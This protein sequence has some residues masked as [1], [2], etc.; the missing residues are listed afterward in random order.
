MIYSTYSI[1]SPKKLYKLSKLGGAGEVIWTKSKRKAVFS[2]ENVHY[3]Q[4]GPLVWL[5][6][7]LERIIVF[8]KLILWHKMRKLDRG[9]K[10][11]LPPQLTELTFL[12]ALPSNNNPHTQQWFSS[13]QK[14]CYQKLFANMPMT[15]CLKKKKESCPIT[16]SAL[17]LPK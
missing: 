10:S 16:K 7:E 8:S 6:F 5:D 9:K 15:I 4:N 17:E 11:E 1:F 14:Y 2:Q 12:S 3:Y 13:E